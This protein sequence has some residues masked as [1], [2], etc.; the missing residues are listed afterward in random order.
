MGSRPSTTEGKAM[1]HG[2]PLKPEFSGFPAWT[3]IMAEEAFHRESPSPIPVQGIG[4][5]SV[6]LVAGQDEC[7]VDYGPDSPEE[8]PSTWTTNAQFAFA[9]QSAADIDAVPPDALPPIHDKHHSQ[10]QQQ[11]QQFDEEE[12]RAYQL[13]RE[14]S[15]YY[16][17]NAAAYA[18]KD[19]LTGAGFSKQIMR[20]ADPRSRVFQYPSPSEALSMMAKRPHARRIAPSNS[21][22]M[23]GNKPPAVDQTWYTLKQMKRQWLMQYSK[24]EGE[25]REPEPPKS[26]P[27]KRTRDVDD[28]TP[29]DTFNRN[30]N[31]GTRPYTGGRRPNTGSRPNSTSRPNTGSR[32][33]S[34]AASAS[35]PWCTSPGAED[36]HLNSPPSF[37]LSM[38]ASRPASKPVHGYGGTPE[39]G[40]QT[41]SSHAKSPRFDD[42]THER[43]QASF[44]STP[45][46]SKEYAAFSSHD[47][48]EQQQHDA[49]A[50]IHAAG[51]EIAIDARPNAGLSPIGETS[52]SSLGDDSLAS[53][54]TSPQLQL[55]LS[56]EV[57]AM[58]TLADQKP[59]TP[60]KG[61]PRGG[62]EAASPTTP[63]ADHY[64][65]DDDPFGL[66]S[67]R[68]QR[69]IVSPAEKSPSPRT[70][71][72]A[73]S[74]V[75]PRKGPSPVQS[76]SSK[77]LVGM[78]VQGSRSF[79]RKKYLQPAVAQ[80][81][82]DKNMEGPKRRKT[83]TRTHQSKA[84]DCARH[85]E[86]NPWPE[87]QHVAI[88]SPFFDSHIS[89]RELG[90]QSVEK[91]TAE[92][93]KRNLVR[94]ELQRKQLVADGN[95]ALLRCQEDINHNM[96]K[97]AMSY[98][99]I[100][101]N[102]FTKA[103]ALHEKRLHLD[104]LHHRILHMTQEY[105]DFMY[106]AEST[107][108]PSPPASPTVPTVRA[109]LRGPD[110][111]QPDGMFA[112]SRDEL[113]EM[114]RRA[115]QEE[116][117][118]R[119][120]LIEEA[121][122]SAELAAQLKRLESME[123]QT[124]AKM[125][126]LAQTHQV[127]TSEEELAAV[128]EAAAN[129]AADSEQDDAEKH[130]LAELKQRRQKEREWR[131]R[132]LAEERRYLEEMERR[133]A[134]EE[135]R[136]LERQ[137]EERAKEEKKRRLAEVAEEEEKRKAREA[138]AK[139]KILEE[140]A[141]QKAEAR[142]T[143][144]E[145]QKRAQAVADWLKDLITELEYGEEAKM[146]LE[147]ARRAAEEARECAEEARRLQAI[148][149]LAAHQAASRLAQRVHQLLQGVRRLE[150]RLEAKLTPD[151]VLKFEGA[152]KAVSAANKAYNE[153]VDAVC[154]A[155]VRQCME[156]L[157]ND[158]ESVDAQEKAEK[159]AAELAEAIAATTED[160][161]AESVEEVMH[162]VIDEM[163]LYCARIARVEVQE[164]MIAER[165]RR[166][167]EARREEEERKRREEEER[168][169][170]LAAAGVLAL[171]VR[172]AI[173]G[174]QYSVTLLELFAEEERLRQEKERKR[175][176]EEERLA[177][178][179]AAETLQAAVGRKNLSESY[180]KV[181]VAASA[182]EAGFR[183]SV[184]RAE[185]VASVDAAN[186]LQMTAKQAVARTTYL[187]W[188]QAA[189]TVQGLVR[190]MP[191]KDAHASRRDQ[192]CCL[193]THLR[194]CLERRLLSISLQSQMLLGAYIRQQLARQDFSL[195]FSE[196]PIL[197]AAFKRNTEAY[198][199][200]IPTMRACASTLQT[201]I[202]RKFASQDLKRKLAVMVLEP[203][204]QSTAAR[205][206]WF[207]RMSA[208]VKVFWAVKAALVAAG[209]MESRQA[210]VSLQRAVRRTNDVA[211]Y[212]AEA[213]ESR[214][215][216]EEERKR[217]DEEEKARLRE[218]EVARKQKEIMEQ[219]EAKSKAE[220]E[221]REA[222]KAK[223]AE[224]KRM[225]AEYSHKKAE[226]PEEKKRPK[227]PVKLRH[228]GKDDNETFALA[229]G[230]EKQKMY[231]DAV[232]ALSSIIDK[233]EMNDLRL[234]CLL[235][236]ATCLGKL[237]M[238]NDCF[239]DLER[240][241][242]DFPDEY[243][244]YYMRALHHVQW[245]SDDLAM[246]DVLSVLERNPDHAESLNLQANLAFKVGFYVD[247]IQLSTR[248][249]DI[250][251]DLPQLYI[252]R[253]C[254]REKLGLMQQ[255]SD[256]LEK[257][258]ELLLATMPRYDT[259]AD[260]Q[261]LKS[262]FTTL[263]DG[264]FVVFCD[265]C[266]ADADTGAQ[267]A[268]GVLSKM[269]EFTSKRGVV[270]ALRARAYC[271][272][273]QFS[274]AEEDFASAVK[275]EENNSH[276]L[277]LQA[278]FLR[279]NDPALAISDC[280]NATELDPENARAHLVLGKLH[281]QQH[282]S[283]E[284]LEA[285]MKVLDCKDIG[286]RMLRYEAALRAG[287]LQFKL[288][289]N[290]S[291]QKERAAELLREAARSNPPAADPFLSLA[292]KLEVSGA[293]KAAIRHLNRLIH[294]HPEDPRNYVLRA[295]CFL[296]M[297]DRASATRDRQTALQ[298]DT[299][300]D[301]DIIE[302]KI[303][304]LVSKEEYDQGLAVL[305]DAMAANPNH[306][307][308]KTLE[309]QLLFYKGD[310]DG[311]RA[312]F[313][314]CVRSGTANS[315]TYRARALFL[316]H[317]GDHETAVNQYSQALETDSENASIYVGRGEALLMTRRSNQAVEDLDKALAI[318]G[319]PEH[320]DNSA[321][322][323]RAL[324]LRAMALEV[325]GNT[326]GALQDYALILEL[327]AAEKTKVL[328]TMK[329][330]AA[331]SSKDERQFYFFE[332]HMKSGLLCTKRRDFAG[333]IDH[334]N[335]VLKVK[336]QCVQALLHRGVAYHSHGYHDSGIHDYTRA[337]ALEPE[338]SIVLQNR[339][340]AWACQRNW[341]KAI[342]DIEAIP[343][344]NRDVEVWSLLA[345]CYFQNAQKEA[346]LKAINAALQLDNLSLTALVNP[347]PPL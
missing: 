8:A 37:P 295:Q 313:D 225:L 284:A 212:Q 173:C 300:T 318:N 264:V 174:A 4:S 332:A 80:V 299:R 24:S 340:Q 168:L 250:K 240:A 124:A 44:T 91:V 32:P 132:I 63:W 65:R 97:R 335:H 271:A 334:Y 180:A 307:H 237:G 139:R 69:V 324:H 77:D 231:P 263:N 205:A 129:T 248:A 154:D 197:V 147:K 39:T 130:R 3:Q 286:V 108:T 106:H 309:A 262:L 178:Q 273:H 214:R 274:K 138:E 239:K 261:D 7:A 229:V 206:A 267:R 333:A 117:L 92:D 268:V 150:R 311:A 162:D 53:P 140:E 233:K 317:T 35:S 342:S 42:H 46:M 64:Q 246:R 152:M 2:P 283:R 281:E 66:G 156:Q 210:V 165:K 62:V 277:L 82:Q 322:I 245:K 285:Y 256:D 287:T 199:L 331:E 232:T 328:R 339:A 204:L 103:E 347:P 20:L 74:P 291:Y 67:M 326:A 71:R 258:I 187:E 221:A 242:R 43:E 255:A 142:R 252:I 81:T 182:L 259:Q 247:A 280:K 241:M 105:Q 160:A 10:Q 12:Q 289:E 164:E 133:L 85:V 84:E 57:H 337:L 25:M 181:L 269:I 90:F 26:K 118:R 226:E 224:R 198:H 98:H 52:Y 177:K 191:I 207:A 288:A 21:V 49:H 22:V 325:D 55:G 170:K 87:L 179:Y 47:M 234:A 195:Y 23:V 101:A 45:S 157:I 148:H 125:H 14:T 158:V 127:Q 33:A 83:E 312:K 346:A 183:C 126:E 341:R 119:E 145:E 169:A 218:E 209:Y 115:L 86:Q 146:I 275:A 159:E 34:K 290:S 316:Q 306:H 18:T 153:A 270:F 238:R 128:E 121:K 29:Q 109:S 304:H 222:E 338:N 28:A 260:E 58:R 167:E 310:L 123:A 190:T 15:A 112:K 122:R 99:R 6:R 120:H 93:K 111:L 143:A 1:S 88:H 227:T 19:V 89:N 172:R 302:L 315:E 41:P 196:F 61:S 27:T 72:G 253:G 265:A 272:M 78:Q 16:V 200:H 203:Y 5:V 327:V 70:P 94:L 31:V 36:A 114:R 79:P 110:R 75:S 213:L 184:S 323:I 211:A 320:G 189:C 194:S 217:L 228:A 276:V 30:G 9:G 249:L 135:R 38:P 17:D 330:L 235:K 236:R 96:L 60:I 137:G 202:R 329:D 171:F 149:T 279:N 314:D 100:A 244:P 308:F 104:Q 116:R 215:I 11:Q 293:H 192:A 51:R 50:Y 141:K 176:E 208:A 319:H 216:E 282:N 54:P 131:K 345:T 68:P 321:L 243:L 219:M 40:Y 144:M 155:H 230:Y 297:G 48:H 166:E 294:M 134:E 296:L 343:E 73:H 163:A 185:F 201:Y 59:R 95:R 107:K 257:A 254:S 186:S 301:P 220:R 251:R 76:P 188:F 56:M 193:Q 151:H 136:R 336:P 278:Q 161:A 298:L 113:E 223:E 175:R 344:G 292:K 266:L 303:E 305:R 13:Y 102:F